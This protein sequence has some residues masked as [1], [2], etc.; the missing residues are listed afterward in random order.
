MGARC[1][2]VTVAMK[3]KGQVVRGLV[4]VGKGLGECRE[5][6]NQKFIK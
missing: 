4:G 6:R 5:C 1:K 2:A 3:G